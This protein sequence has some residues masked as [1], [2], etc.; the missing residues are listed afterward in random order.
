MN[1]GGVK[2]NLILFAISLI[3]VPEAPRIRGGFK[4]LQS[5]ERISKAKID[6]YRSGVCIDLGYV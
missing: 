1:S 5:R 3:G 4:L 6:M 2:R